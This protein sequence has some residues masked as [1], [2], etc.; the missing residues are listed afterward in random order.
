MVFNLTHSS[1][2]VRHNRSWHHRSIPE[3]TFSTK[4]TPLGACLLPGR[5]VLWAKKKP[6][7]RPLTELQNIRKCIKAGL[8]YLAKTG[9]E[10]PKRFLAF[11]KW[12]VSSK[13]VDS[14]L[15]MRLWMI[16]QVISCLFHLLHI[17]E[18][19]RLYFR[20]A[21]VKLFPFSDLWWSWRLDSCSYPYII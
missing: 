8:S 18:V 11:E 9:W 14:T 3:R 7:P 15:H 16:A 20:S 19:S 10:S 21:W 1:I 13:L 6:I 4:D 5:T 12:H 17:S 2:V